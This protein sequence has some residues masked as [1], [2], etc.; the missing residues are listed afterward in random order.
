MERGISARLS[1]VK[2]FSLR[3][4]AARAGGR[5]ASAG[6][7]EPQLSGNDLGSLGQPRLELRP[8]R[9]GSGE[10][11]ELRVRP[12]CCGTALTLKKEFDVRGKA[13]KTD[14][15]ARGRTP[16]FGPYSRNTVS[17]MIFRSFLAGRGDV[18]SRFRRAER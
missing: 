8:E 2:S 11:C 7:G 18:R 16:P 15:G 5:G 1:V 10:S 4:F 13:T 14:A 6:R 9:G 12:F 17:W 3:D